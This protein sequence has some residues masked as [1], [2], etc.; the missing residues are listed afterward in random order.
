M[1]GWWD[2]ANVKAAH[3]V[4][5]SLSEEEITF[6]FGASEPV[7]YMPQNG[8]YLNGRT[9]ARIEKNVIF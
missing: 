5:K 7:K 8:K 4:P 3:L 2:N 9:F 1:T 6:L